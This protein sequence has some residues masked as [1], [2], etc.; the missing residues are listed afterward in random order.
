MRGFKIKSPTI[1]KIIKLRNRPR[2]FFF[3]VL[4]FCNKKKRPRP[5]Q[6]IPPLPRLVI[7]TISLSRMG[8]WIDSKNFKNCNSILI[9]FFEL[10]LDKLNKVL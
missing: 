5:I 10:I 6:K 4:L 9:F 2:A 1:E 8:E 3:E 7:K